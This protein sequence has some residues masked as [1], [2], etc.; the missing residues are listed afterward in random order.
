MGDLFHD[1]SSTQTAT[2]NQ[3]AVQGGG[4]GSYTLGI[5]AGANVKL[6]DPGAVALAHDTLTQ[7]AV[8]I[9]DALNAVTTTANNALLNSANIQAEVQQ[10]AHDAFDTA[11]AAIAATPDVQ[12]SSA[13]ATVAASSQQTQKMLLIGGAAIALVAVILLMKKR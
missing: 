3:V 4:T 2:N 5:G 6:I 8:V 10:V 13:V 7:Q 1:S 11:H 9:H 12:L